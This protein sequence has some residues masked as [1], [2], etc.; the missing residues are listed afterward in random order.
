[1]ERHLDDEL[2]NYKLKLLKMT[3]LVEDAIHQSIEALRTRNKYLA[4]SVIKRD[5]EIDEMENEIEEQAIELLAL[6]QPM[7]GDLRF[8]TTGMHVNT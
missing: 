3:A 1:M 4:E 7:A 5:N 6:F 8:I 2:K